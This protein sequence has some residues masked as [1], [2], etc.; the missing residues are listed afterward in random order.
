MMDLQSVYDSDPAYDFG[1]QLERVLQLG[2]LTEG[3]LRFTVA[4]DPFRPQ[5]SLGNVVQG[6]DS[7]AV[8][9]KFYPPSGYR[10]SC[11]GTPPPKPS[12]FQKRFPFIYLPPT[13][14]KHQRAQWVSRYGNGVDLD[15][16]ARQ[17][18]A[19]AHERKVPVFSHHTPQ[20]FE[21][22]PAHGKSPGYG[23]RMA[24]PC[25][26]RGVL[27]EIGHDF[28][29]ILAHSGGGDGWFTQDEWRGSFDQEAYDLCTRYPNVYCDFGMSTEILNDTGRKAFVARLTHLIAAP[30]PP[31]EGCGDRDCVAPLPEPR[32]DIL[33]KLV[34]GSDWHMMARVKDRESLVCAF[35]EAFSSTPELRAAAAR[36]FGANAAR[37][38]GLD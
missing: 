33:D 27:D 28:R 23:E 38:F 6:M 31:H 7:G 21:A 29:L 36:F 24:R 32:Y 15:A 3:K 26:W 2:E 20:G 34:F 17:L 10:P 35:G 11:N 1:R 37:A 16:A 25:Y 13:A 12:Y 30:P 9:V 5:A 14:R 18:F 4:Y 8:A 22:Q 19:L